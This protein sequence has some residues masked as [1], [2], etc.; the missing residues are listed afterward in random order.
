MTR[1]V[2]TVLILAGVMATAACNTVRGL[3]DGGHG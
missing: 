3:G 1:T 2:L